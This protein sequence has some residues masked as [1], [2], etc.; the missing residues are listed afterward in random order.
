MYLLHGSSIFS[1]IRKWPPLGTTEHRSR[2]IECFHSRG[3]HLCKF[4]GTKESVCVR[5]EFNSQRS[6]LG[7]Q[8]GRRFIV[9][10]HQ[11]GRRDV[12]WKHSICRWSYDALFHW[13]QLAPQAISDG[14]QSGLDRLHKGQITTK[15][16]LV[17]R[18]PKQ[19]SLPV[20]GSRKEWITNSC[21]FN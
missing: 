15:W 9:L 1:C 7:Q 4:I 14:L 20:N 11:Y 6:G 10:G 21:K 12:M 19:R 13:L 18:R 16:F 3:Q 8:H 2:H 17:K 5:K